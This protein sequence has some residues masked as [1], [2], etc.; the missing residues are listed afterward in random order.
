MQNPAGT[1]TQSSLTDKPL[2]KILKSR[3]QVRKKAQ[4]S[5]IW[6]ETKTEQNL[7]AYDSVLTLNQSTAEITLQ[8]DSRISM[9]ENTLVVIE[10]PRNGEADGPLRLRFKKGNLQAR[11]GRS[12][13]S[14]ETEE[15]VVEAS[16][17]TKMNIRTTDDDKIQIDAIE[18]EVKLLKS[19]SL[20]IAQVVNAGE[21]A[22]VGENKI[23]VQKTAQIEWNIPVDGQKIYTHLDK[24]KINFQWA[25][26]VTGLSVQQ[27]ATEKPQNLEIDIHKAQDNYAL[28][29]EHGNY[30]VKLHSGDVSTF[31]RQIAVWPA[32]KIHLVNPVIRQRFKKDA[33]IQFLW[34]QTKDVEA[35]VFELALDPEFKKV[36]RQ[37]KTPQMGVEIKVSAV[38]EFYWRVRGVDN[39][40]FEIPELY[41]N[42]F[43]ILDKPLEAPKLKSP[44]IIREES[45]LN[46]ENIKLQNREQSFFSFMLNYVVNLIL[47]RANAESSMPTK[48]LPQS[49]FAEFQWEP[50]DG[51]AGYVVEISR[52]PNFR[53][54]IATANVKRESFKWKNFNLGQYYWRVAARDI[55]GEQG[56]FSE[57]AFADL[58]QI[59]SGPIK[60]VAPPP[61]A[62][63]SPPPPPPKIK[64]VEP[65]I[66]YSH[67]PWDFKIEAG[68][69]GV[70]SFQKGEDFNARLFGFALFDSRITIKPPEHNYSFWQAELEFHMVSAKGNPEGQ[71]PF[72]TKITAPT[73]KGYFIKN[74]SWGIIAGQYPIFK[75]SD[76]EALEYSKPLAG[77]IFKQWNTDSRIYRVGFVGGQV[78]ALDSS[79]RESWNLTDSFDLSGELRLIGGYGLSKDIFVDL[80]AHFWLGFKF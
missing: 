17:D 64:V 18:G 71:F 73:F 76:L 74:N 77:G 68:G 80:S 58:N 49:Y 12:P 79:A 41:Y 36:I 9:N 14:I 78:F 37:I 75:R 63:A 23:D 69:H 19:D 61:V 4:D 11:S 16:R 53:D 28:D 30:L 44:Q 25:G 2:G 5:L 21:S 34:T 1:S 8:G 51:A 47:P 29:L 62:V 43:F 38:G 6:E 42:N 55:T 40:N 57:T 24:A 13:Q 26:E 54:L 46:K 10:P 27:Q 33:P 59:P 72:Q 52:S 15:Y 3:S 70:Y 7:F 45:Q 60:P 66:D 32:P 35:Y 67:E 39:A 20:T 22:K 50:V 31:A 48:D 56:L 65:E